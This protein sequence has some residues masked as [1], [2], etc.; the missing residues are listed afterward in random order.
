VDESASYVLVNMAAFPRLDVEPFAPSGVAAIS[1]SDELVALIFSRLL[2]E[3]KDETEYATSVSE[4]ALH[5]AYQ[6]IIGLGPQVVPLI[7]RELAAELDHW[8]WALASI[9]GLDVA[10]GATT[11]ADAAT[12]WTEWAQAQGLV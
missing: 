10:E 3:W 11:L 12:R 4:A 6:Q 9:T 7:I 1:R 8:F 2:R 5:P